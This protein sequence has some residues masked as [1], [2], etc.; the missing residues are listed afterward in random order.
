MFLAEETYVFSLIVTSLWFHIIHLAQID[1]TLWKKVN[2]FNNL[3]INNLMNNRRMLWNLSN[4]SDVKWGS[5]RRRLI[6]ARVLANLFDNLD[7]K[8]GVEYVN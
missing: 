6:W 4:N 2:S 7:N 3:D 8:W 5:N 1:I